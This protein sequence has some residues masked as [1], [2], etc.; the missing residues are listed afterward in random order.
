MCVC[1]CVRIWIPFSFIIYLA[2]LVLCTIH[3]PTSEPSFPRLGQMLVD[4]DTPLKKL[5]EDFLPISKPLSDALESLR[6]VFDRRYLSVEAMRKDSYMNIL[7]NPAKVQRVSS[8]G[9]VDGGGGRGWLCCGS[10]VSCMKCW[11]CRCGLYTYRYNIRFALPL[12]VS[13]FCCTYIFIH[14]LLLLLLLLLLSLSLSKAVIPQRAWA[15]R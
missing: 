15:P 5:Y 8:A 10:C 7:Q 9:G 2:R 13:F 11:P 4:F 12:L 6:P 3:L 1:E 14:I